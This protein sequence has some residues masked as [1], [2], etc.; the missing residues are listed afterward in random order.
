MP[1]F[2]DF[3]KEIEKKKAKEKKAGKEKEEKKKRGKEKKETEQQ[4]TEEKEEKSEIKKEEKEKVEQQEKK[5]NEEKKKEREEKEIERQQVKEKKKKLE[6][7]KEETRE[8]DDYINNNI[9]KRNQEVEKQTKKA[10]NNAVKNIKIKEIDEDKEANKCNRKIREI[11]EITSFRELERSILKQFFEKKLHHAIMLSG[12]Y[13]IGKAT[14]AYWIVT[15]MILSQFN[16]HEELR[17]ANFELLQNNI[18]PDVFFLTLSPD[19]N[20]IGVDDVRCLLNKLYLKSTYGSKFVIIDD[21]DS[22]NV[23]GLN[24]L[25]KTLEEQPNNTYFF[26]INHGIAKVLDTIYSRCC[27]IDLSITTNECIDILHKLYK[28]WTNEDVEFYTKI[29]GNS[30]AFAKMLFDLNIK[31][32]ITEY[33]SYSLSFFRNVIAIKNEPSA[34]SNT[35]KV[36][37]DKKHIFNKKTINLLN[38][39]YYEIDKKYKSL[40]KILKIFLLEKIIVYLLNENISIM[41]NK[42]YIANIDNNVPAESNDVTSNNIDDGNEYT[43]QGSDEF[44]KQI[45]A[46]N[47][48]IIK[49]LIDIKTFDLPVQF[50]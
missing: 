37:N 46:M 38:G 8:G 14:F 10:D 1:L 26:I 50:G 12:D 34:V 39:I 20:E 32:C 29:S 19:E 22:V 18:H 9:V 43:E 23:N 25:L 33:S 41:N 15:Q 31:Q 49:Q 3:E 16:E 40:S 5:G 2:D 36:A 27:K 35:K 7:K 47:A 44:T 24:A 45:V 6:T 17:N 30:V 4:Q 42:N 48:K 21:I 11:K 28:D 13:G